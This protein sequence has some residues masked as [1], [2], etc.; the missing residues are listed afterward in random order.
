MISF[1]RKSTFY[2]FYLVL[3]FALAELLVRSFYPEFVG[4]I[5]ALRASDEQGVMHY[6]VH[7]QKLQIANVDTVLRRVQL[8][9][10]P[11]DYDYSGKDVVLVVGDSITE[12]YGNSYE[13][14]WWSIA[15]RRLKL[16]YEAPPEIVPIAG[17]GGNTNDVIKSI[18]RHLH[19][20]RQRAKRVLAVVYQFNMN[21]IHP[22]GAMKLAEPEAIKPSEIND[23]VSITLAKLKSEFELIRGQYL[24]HSAF[25]R[26]LTH[27]AYRLTRQ[28]DG[29]CDGRGLGA[30]GQYSWAYGSKPFAEEANRLWHDFE[31]KIS[32][33][34]NALNSEGT[35]F[36]ILITP[37]VYE[38]D[39]SGDHVYSY[40]RNGYDFTCAT[41]DP[42]KKLSDISSRLGINIVD[43][44]Q[45][46]RQIYKA[47]KASGNWQRFYFINDD[48]HINETGSRYFSE[49]FYGKIMRKIINGAEN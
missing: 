28:V 26:L 38:I 35:S 45:Y 42:T 39:K 22:Y 12:G 19:R 24:N 6:K 27:Y 5:W 16:E 2:V 43:P 15:D 7:N 33:L 49:Y 17:A 20:V 36:Y 48:N 23:K 3:L 44:T 30:L 37:T 29:L 21:D 40:K 1:F 13:N 32:Q 14:V 11:S 34:S 10:R 4:G 41:I 9:F 18:N 47:K 46:M 31:K 8:P 25:L